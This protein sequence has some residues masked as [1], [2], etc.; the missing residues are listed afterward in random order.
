MGVAGG[1]EVYRLDPDGAPRRVWGNS[2]DVVYAIAFDSSGR[3]LLGAGNKGNI[4]RIES[5]TMYTTLVA[6][7]ATQVTAFQAGRDGRLFAA[8]GNPGKVYEIGPGLEHDGWIESDV[9]DSG[10]YSLWGRLSFEANL[11]GG[12]VAM[13]TRSGNLD[14]PQK[15]WS[16]WTAVPDGGKGGRVASPAARFVQW[17]ATLTGGRPE[18][19]SV[20]VAYLPKNLEP[21]IDEIEA[22]P[23]NYRFPPASTPAIAFQ[24]SLSLPPMGKRA[25]PSGGSSTGSATSM[26]STASI[27]SANTPAMQFAKG[28]IGA[29]WMA[30]DPNGD[31][32]V[33]TV[34]IRG[35]GETEWKLLKDKVP[36]RYISW[37][38]TAYPDG[39]Y[40][41]RVTASDAPGNPP[42]EALTARLEGS[43]FWIDNTPP[44]ITT[45]AGA[46][47]GGKLQVKWHA[48][49]ALNNI[50]KAEYSLDGSD[51]KVAA[52]VTRL[53]DAPEL[54]YELNLDAAAGEHTIAVRVEDE[55]GNQAV[56]KTVVK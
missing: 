49:D 7:P 3:A 25:G 35:V 30:S 16:A 9:F 27:T 8:T 22:T 47:T 48:A 50:A 29:R 33:F 54:D 21:R 52:P 31:A 13:A 11:N 28:F 26:D 15:N 24:P 44:K 10:L 55:Y 17:R 41:I 37:D 6:L 2:L 23:A 32:L 40:R 19:D 51:W 39:E 12:Q 5:P 4:Y 1:S 45:L 14:R 20:D 43:P 36:E 42:A 46:R 56:E 38:S 18:L 53:S 34:E